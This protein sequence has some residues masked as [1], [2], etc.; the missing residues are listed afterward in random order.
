MTQYEQKFRDILA[1]ILQLDQAE[2]DFGIYRIMNQKRKDI[3]AF[4]NNR[5]VPEVTK[6][7][8]TQTAAGTDIS[9]MENEVFSHLAKFF[10]RY[11]EGGDFISKRRYKDDAYAIPYS[12]EEVKLYWAN[13]DQYYIK[14]SEYFK[15]YSFVLPT[16]RRKVHFVLRDAD[17]EQNNN[18]AAN[19]MERRFQLCEED[20]IAEEDGELNIFFTYELMPK[21]IKQDALIKDAEAKIISLFEKGKYVDFAELVNEK[22]PT[23]KN[24]ERTL[25]MKHLQ[26]YTAKN[27]FDYF[28]HKDL[29]GFLRRELDF[30]IKNEV[31]FLDDL[32]A[33]HIM[34]HL[35]QVKAIKQVGEKIITF[36]AQLEDFQKKLWLKKKF[37]VG[38]DYCITLDRIPRTLYPEIIANDEQRK[39]WVRLFAIDEIKGDMM[40]EGYSEPLTEKF[41]EDNPFLVLDTKFFSAEF[42]HKLVGSMEK[43]DE[44]C[45]G[46]LINS[47]NFQALELLQ[48]KCSERV[49]NI[50][51]DPP[52]NTS[53]SEIMYKNSYKHSSWLSLLEDRIRLGK[54]LLLDSGIQCTTIDDVEQSRLSLLLQDTF[55]ELPETVTIRI[56]PSGRPIPNGFAISHEYAL[57]SKKNLGTSIARLTHS[58][59]Q[60]ARYREKDDKGRFLWE[61]LRKAGSNSF[62]ENRPTMYYPLFVNTNSLIVRLPK[63]RYEERT[64]EFVLEEQPLADEQIVF[65]IKDDGKE[66]RW[67]YGVERAV[68]EQHELKAVRNN[69]SSFDIY[70]R[71]RPN[72]GV[73]PTT[74][75]ID[76]KYSATEHGTDLLKRL[77]GQQEKFSYPK[78][79]YAVEDCL[80]VSGMQSKSIAL[81]YFAGSGTTGHAVIN[82]NREDNGNRKYILCEMAEYFNSVTKPRIEKVIYSEDWKDGKPVSRKGISQ[83]FKYIRLEQYEDTL[84]N[85]QPKNQRLDFDN[86]NG[87]G[88]F[89]ETY[90]LRY[91]LDTETKGDLFNLE[92]FKNP[93]AMSIKTTKDNELVD[94]HV[95]MVETFN[96]LIGLNVETLRY[97]KDGYCVVEGTTH[98]GNERT[99]VIWRNCHKVSNEDLNEFFRKQAYSTTDSEFDKIYVNGD[100]TLPNIKT[101]EEHWK[102]VLIEEE[103]KKRMFE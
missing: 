11:Y 62:R 66:G 102:V 25:L 100:N 42:K 47:E 12:G 27:N 87:K 23:E 58:E 96:Y 45:N 16:S 18:K 80:R 35:A 28:I 26:D 103:F 61:L 39:E 68:N 101:D 79:V 50:Y 72:E 15:N 88:D 97:P 49:Q 76:S 24:K 29:G 57:F 34:E 6:I 22:V 84:N 91:M 17:T 78:S 54:K 41:L 31:M 36:L 77:F 74:S 4:L 37:V 2:L 63:M 33:T 85:L 21:T 95:D 30:Y 64:S 20:C 99:L 81:D 9:A 59:E 44:E 67:Y 65:P 92:W 98:I 40:T 1:E 75:W 3:E 19:N 48:E 51:A 90:F 53:A 82:L 46:L 56:K 38:C 7:L 89:E 86:E 32:D 60:A 70:R 10:S 55:A 73:Q 14:T 94:T 13:A 83:C 8:K 93:F 69:R 43:V 52:Y 5:L 71:R